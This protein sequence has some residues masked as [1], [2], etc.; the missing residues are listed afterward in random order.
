MHG[1]CHSAAAALATAQL[2]SGQDL[3]AVE[4]GF[5]EE[6]E[7]ED[8]ED[9]LEAFEDHVEAVAAVTFAGDIVAMVFHGP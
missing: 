9:L 6:E 2:R 8:H 3:L 1:V 5:P 7:P 4:P